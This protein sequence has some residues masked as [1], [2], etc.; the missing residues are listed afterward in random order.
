MINL[1]LA[2]LQA[3]AES[4]MNATITIRHRSAA[5]QDPGDRTG[6]NTVAYDT[7]Q[8]ENV[9]GWFVDKGTR[10]FSRDGSM[11]VITNVPLLRVPVG[12]DIKSRDEVL[13]NGSKWWTVVDASGD[14]TWPVWLKCELARIE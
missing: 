1:D 8:T 2:G 5:A 12:T 3:I 7:I 6:D 11:S 9:K 4:Y 14:E 13:I 10:S